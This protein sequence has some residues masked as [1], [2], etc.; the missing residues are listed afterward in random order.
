MNDVARNVLRE[1]SYTR[2]FTAAAFKDHIKKNIIM[3]DI[4]DFYG[5]VGDAD[6]R[7]A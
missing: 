6:A 7:K 5:M 2:D 3:A 1:F 4:T